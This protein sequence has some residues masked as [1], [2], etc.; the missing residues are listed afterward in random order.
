MFSKHCTQCLVH[1]KLSMRGCP[2]FFGKPPTTSC[3][4][5]FLL[6]LSCGKSTSVDNM[7]AKEGGVG[8]E[9]GKKKYPVLVIQRKMNCLNI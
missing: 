3:L 5:F 7:T 2:Y 1:Y 4:F 8:G 6:Y 9:L